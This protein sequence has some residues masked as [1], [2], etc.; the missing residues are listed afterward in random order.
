MNRSIISAIGAVALL[1]GASVGSVAAD[2]MVVVIDRPDLQTL[3]KAQGGTRLKDLIG[4]QVYSNSGVEI[5]EIEDFVLT[6][7]GFLYAVVD[8]D[9]GPLGKLIEWPDGDKGNVVV[10]WDQLRMAGVSQL[11]KAE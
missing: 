4:T 11:P 1:T 3:A 10:P 2:E 7:G 9:D 8:T 5:G 6:Q